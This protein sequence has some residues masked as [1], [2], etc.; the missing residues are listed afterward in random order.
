V[1]PF[2]AH[3][4]SRAVCAL[5]LWLNDVVLVRDRNADLS[6]DWE[7]LLNQLISSLL[8]P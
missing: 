4:E 3:D 2:A 8:C 5:E 1:S 6:P 7:I